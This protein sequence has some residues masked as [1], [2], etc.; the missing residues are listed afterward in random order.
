MI[1]S[2]FYSH[3]GF[4]VR[5]R[6]FAS[7]AK[8]TLPDDIVISLKTVFG[9]GYMPKNIKNPLFLGIFYPKF[10]FWE[11]R[12]RFWERFWGNLFAKMPKGKV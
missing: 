1:K 6:F 11:N 12:F 10:D 2:E 4:A 7:C 8:M 9:S 5:I 3:C